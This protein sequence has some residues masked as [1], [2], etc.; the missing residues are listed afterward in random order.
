V[1]ESAKRIKVRAEKMG[2][3]LPMSMI[4]RGVLCSYRLA[5]KDKHGPLAG[6]ELDMDGLRRLNEDILR[7][8]IKRHS[9]D[10]VKDN[11]APPRQAVL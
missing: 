9:R 4:V 11:V 1:N 10:R 6:P 5:A 3:S 2:E 7:D 8:E